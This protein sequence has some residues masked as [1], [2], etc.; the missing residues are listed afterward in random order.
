MFGIKIKTTTR[1]TEKRKIQTQKN[2]TPA[3]P[4]TKRHSQQQQLKNA[5]PQETTPKQRTKQHN[6]QRICFLKSNYKANSKARKQMSNKSPPKSGT[7]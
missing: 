6:E 3:K 7:L 1:S 2:A 4:Q 5:K